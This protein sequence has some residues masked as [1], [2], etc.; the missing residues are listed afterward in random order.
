MGFELSLP[1]SEND[2]GDC[3]ASVA[4]SQGFIRVVAYLVVSVDCARLL[5]EW[6]VLRDVVWEVRVLEFVASKTD[7]FGG[8]LLYSAFRLILIRGSAGPHF[9][10]YNRNICFS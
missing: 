1:F 4:S 9:V 5:D 2:N 7:R 8:V 3:R 6:L 10:L